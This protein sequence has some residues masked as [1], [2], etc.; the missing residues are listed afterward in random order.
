MS[1]PTKVLGSNFPIFDGTEAVCWIVEMT[2][3]VSDALVR[4]VAPGVLY[5][6]VIIQDGVGGHTF[7]WPS[8]CINPP[9]INTQPDGKTVVN[10]IGAGDGIIAAS[11]PAAWI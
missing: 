6:I 2:S 7:R 4:Y 1:R 5:T 9:Q 10:F 8:N 11:A 3:S